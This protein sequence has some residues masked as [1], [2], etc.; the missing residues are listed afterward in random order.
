[1]IICVKDN[2]HANWLFKKLSDHF[3]VKQN[4]L[5]RCL[6]LNISHNRENKSITLSRDEYGLDLAN[7]YKTLIDHFPRT[8]TCLPY[9]IE[10]SRSQCPSSDK[11]KEIMKNK[12]YREILG[13]LN[14]YTCTLRTDINFAVNYLARFMDNPGIDHWKCLLH[15]LAYIRDQ[16]YAYITYKDIRYTSFLIDGRIH[17]V[18]KNRLYCFVDAD[19]A[20]SDVDNRRSV[21]GYIIFYNGGVISWKSSLQRRVSASSTEAEYRALHEACKE[22][23]W[24]THILDEL[25]YQHRA[26]AIVFEDNTS[27]IAATQNP[28]AHSKLKHLDTIYHQ[29]RDFIKDDQVNIVHVD[30]ENQLADLLTKSLP[31]TRYRQLVDGVLLVQQQSRQSNSTNR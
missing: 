12:P 11:E 10:L 22:C 15:L 20:T 29:I 3:V 16:P 18:D 24:L 28:V 14:Y 25:G 6:G 26:P 4:N 8:E 9:P 21:T 19:F 17:Q 7:D 2:N 30:T 13:K 1:M 31:P 5:T 27:T 23:V